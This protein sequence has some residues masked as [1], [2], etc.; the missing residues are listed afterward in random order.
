MTP[1][2][3]ARLDPRTSGMALRK[4]M[5]RSTCPPTDFVNRFAKRRRVL[6]LAS[7]LSTAIR[8]R[9]SGRECW[10]GMRN[11][12]FEP[13]SSLRRREISPDRFAY[14]AFQPSRPGDIDALSNIFRKVQQRALPAPVDLTL[15]WAMQVGWCGL[16]ATLC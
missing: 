4:K 11:L 12:R 6:I 3:L 10:S 13:F 2:A 14:I 15:L 5:A 8:R 9:F 16:L 7:T 1:V